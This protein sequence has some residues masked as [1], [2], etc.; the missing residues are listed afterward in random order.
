MGP[1]FGVAFILA[2]AVLAV[3]GANVDSLVTA[4]RITARWSFLLFWIAYCGSALGKLCGRAFA[5]LARRGREFGLA[6]AAAQLIHLGLVVWLFRIS[7]RQPI[8]TRSAIFFSIGIF[9][10]YLLAVLS[11]G[12]FAEALGP[13]GWRAVRVTGMNYILLAFGLDFIAPLIH[14]V[15]A[16]SLSPLIAYVPFAAMSVAAPILVLAAAALYQ[17]EMRYSHSDLGPA[18]G[19]AN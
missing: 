16:P 5:P 17:M 6:Y 14:P 8:S 4:L 9:W 12:N 1:A 7:P 18:A 13:R 19:Q 15:A 3:R 11:F 10:T 2:A